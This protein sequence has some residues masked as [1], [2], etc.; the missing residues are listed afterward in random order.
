MTICPQL[1]SCLVQ[2]LELKLAS[3]D[4]GLVCFQHGALPGLNTCLPRV[5]FCCCFFISKNRVL[6]GTSFWVLC[7]VSQGLPRWPSGK[8][9]AC[10]F[11]RCRRR[12][13]DPWV[14]KIPSRRKW[15]PTPVFLPG[16]SQAQRRPVAYISLGRK[17]LDMTQRLNNSSSIMFQN[18][19]IQV[20]GS[21]TVF[22]DIAKDTSSAAFQE[23]ICT[24]IFI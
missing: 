2:V 16:K 20:R 1:G 13:F 15:Q 12:G 17:V 21:Y 5:I 9:S 24:D 23:F 4:C 10:Q 7:V 19:S 18:L 22:R 8:E 3:S 11:R 14:S 6:N